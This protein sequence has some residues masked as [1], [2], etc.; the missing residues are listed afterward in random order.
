MYPPVPIEKYPNR[1]N[2]SGRRWIVLQ[3]NTTQ[4]DIQNFTL[5]QMIQGFSRTINWLYGK[6]GIS[7]VPA[8]NKHQVNSLKCYGFLGKPAGLPIRA[9]LTTQ[10]TIDIWCLQH[11]K[12]KKSLDVQIP[13]ETHIRTKF[14]EYTKTC[15]G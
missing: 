3:D 9:R 8:A 13:V 14:C 2:Q 10:S 11:L 6:H 7:I 5:G 12:H 4:F 15:L 1:K